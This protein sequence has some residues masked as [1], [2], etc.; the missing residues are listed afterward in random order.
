[1]SLKCGGGCWCYDLIKA[2]KKTHKQEKETKQKEAWEQR[3]LDFHPSKR[4]N[5]WEAK[6][7]THK[8]PNMNSPLENCISL[9]VSNDQSLRIQTLSKW[10]ELKIALK[11]CQWEL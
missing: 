10:Y 11:R 5:M 7:G 6:E 3:E 2:Y 1:M 9:E 8:T 4:E